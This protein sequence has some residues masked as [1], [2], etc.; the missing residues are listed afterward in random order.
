MSRIALLSL[1]LCCAQTQFSGAVSSPQ[2]LVR[3]NVAATDSKGEPVTDLAQTDIQLKEDGQVHPLAFFRFAGAKRGMLAPALGEVANQPAPAPTVILIDRWN[4]HLT[5]AASAWIDVGTALQHAESVE[6]VF[7]YF[8][9]A[10]G[11]LY[12]VESLP[13]ADADLRRTPEPT[14]AELRSKLDDAARKLNS[15][16]DVDVLDPI[17]KANTTFKALDAMGAQMASLNGRKNLVWVSHGIPLSVRLPG[18]D[19]FDFTPQVR[20]LSSAY[21]QSQIAIY[22]VDQSSQGA[23]ANLGTLSEQTMQMFSSLTGGRWYPSDNASDAIAGALADARGDYRLAYYTPLRE[24][25]KKEHKIRLDSSRK[26]V[27]LL[28]RQSYF[29]DAK[30]L[31]PA[32]LERAIFTAEAHSPFEATEI[33]VRVKPS[34]VASNKSHFV[35]RVDPSDLMLEQNG[36]NYHGEIALLLASYSQG[37]LKNAPPPANLDINLSPDQ[38]TQAQKGGIV[39]PQDVEVS[40]DID[41]IRVII[42]DRKLYA[43]GSV[44]VPMSK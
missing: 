41:N 12:P 20:A 8:L 35:I 19:W 29:G 14:P 9:T 17:L 3:L 5:T 44:T 40:S 21:S 31:A 39:L 7:V 25:D 27:R 10:H 28:T 34:P 26:G 15:L 6:R 37:A 22:T 18:A 1:A 38:F 23:G 32:T 4:E 43:V 24:K 30:E 11:D 13:A 33:G 2:R 36:G 16:R 42:L